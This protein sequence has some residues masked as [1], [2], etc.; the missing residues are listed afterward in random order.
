MSWTSKKRNKESTHFSRRGREWSVRTRKRYIKPNALCNL[1]TH[2][3]T[4]YLRPSTT[5]SFILQQGIPSAIFMR[6]RRRDFG[7]NC[8]NTPL[9]C[10]IPQVETVN[11]SISLGA[12]F[13]HL[14]FGY[15]L[16]SKVRP[17]WHWKQFSRVQPAS[18]GIVHS[19]HLLSRL[20]TCK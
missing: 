2:G 1:S 9:T 19:V 14:H 4:V 5:K 12:H 15:Y 6:T 13:C 3:T 10:I 8:H 16:V 18:T 20:V 11:A 7:S 17:K